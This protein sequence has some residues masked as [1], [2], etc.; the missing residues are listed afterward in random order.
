MPHF[1]LYCMHICSLTNVTTYFGVFSPWNCILVKFER[2]QANL[3]LNQRSFEHFAY[4]CWNVGPE[5]LEF[6]L[7]SV[8]AMNKLFE[9]TNKINSFWFILLL[10]FLRLFVYQIFILSHDIFTNCS[11]FIVHTYMSN[12]FVSC[13]AYELI[14]FINDQTK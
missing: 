14:S 8:S 11:L 12:F 13:I 5:N 10:F 3:S 6:I 9:R 4:I 2:A 1:W 7:Y